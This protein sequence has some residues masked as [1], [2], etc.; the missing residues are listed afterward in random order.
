[1]FVMNDPFDGGMHT[2]DIYVVKPVF[3]GDAH[4]GYAVTVAHHG[5][6]GG[7]LPGT[8][9]CDNTEVFQE[10]LRLPWIRLYRDGEPIDDVV[11][12]IRA[13]VRIPRMTMGDVNAQLAACTIA[14]RALNELAERYGPERLMQL[15]T[16]LVDHTERIVRREI[17][18]VARRQGD[19]RR[20]PRLG[21]HRR[22]R[23]AHRGRAGD[24]RRRG[25][26]RPLGLGADGA[27]RAQLDALVHRGD[28]LPGGH[29][30]RQL[31]DPDHVRRVPAGERS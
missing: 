12:V 16:R 7:R 11:R 15:M 14:D 13:N 2:P 4:I 28:R 30:R 17:A 8:S 29:V 24:P 3:R 20:L 25:D 23:R 31:R 26:R 22:R 1:M 6:V 19:L 9:A 27:R 18:D 21:R 10:G 5:D